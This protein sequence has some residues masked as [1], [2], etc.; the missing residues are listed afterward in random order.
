MEAST[1]QYLTHVRHKLNWLVFL[2]HSGTRA[3]LVPLLVAAPTVTFHLFLRRPFPVTATL[4]TGAVAVLAWAAWQTWQ[5][6]YQ[7]AEVRAF[8]DSWVGGKGDVLMEHGPA[9]GP[10]P[11]TRWRWAATRAALT[12]CAT[13]FVFQV[14]VLESPLP[15]PLVTHSTRRL[16]EK[17]EE[18][19]KLALLPESKKEELEAALQE[20]QEAT[21]KMSTEE[22]WHANDK[23]NEKLDQALAESQSTLT[24][25]A[26][27]LHNLN[28]ADAADLTALAQALPELLKD[29]P[30]AAAA[31]QAGNLAELAKALQQLPAEELEKLARQ[32]EQLA[33]QAQQLRPDAE[34][35][36]LAEALAKQMAEQGFQETAG[37]EGG[38]GGVDRG[39]GTN[40]R[41]FGNESPELQ[42]AMNNALL[43]AVKANDP[44]VVLEQTDKPAAPKPAT[45]Q[46]GRPVSSG[47]AGIGTEH[48][49][50]EPPTVAPRYR[51]AVGRYFSK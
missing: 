27:A 3:L 45:D 6:R 46:W 47:A 42:A 19:D 12:A 17:L 35:G 32:L 33:A 40:N 39:P 1:S 21:Q 38:R 36:G 24:H 16:E 30:E 10:V 25:A 20:F 44:G 9:T 31:A 22:F 49:T 7:P 50:S 23:F 4:L 5:R 51:P 34:P 29:L 2:E 28:A 18:L 11:A 48:T 41:L 14:P 37:D 13:F 26:A 43:P 8:V 15:A